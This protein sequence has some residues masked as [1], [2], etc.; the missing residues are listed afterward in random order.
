MVLP[1]KIPLEILIRGTE[2]PNITVEEFAN[3]LRDLVFLH[4][5]IWMMASGRFSEST[6]GQRI[7]LAT[8]LSAFSGWCGGA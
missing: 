6:L 4:D 7:D 8:P 1:E 3:F 2:A 5:R